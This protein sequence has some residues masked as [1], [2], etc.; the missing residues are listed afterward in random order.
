MNWAI[1]CAVWV[2]PT[3]SVPAHRKVRQAVD[4]LSEPI[5]NRLQPQPAVALHHEMQMGPAAVAGIAG[6]RQRAANNDVLTFPALLSE[7]ISLQ[8]R[9][10]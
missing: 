2:I 10:R 5:G 1:Y 3:A 8:K 9:K 6:T 4:A 7:E